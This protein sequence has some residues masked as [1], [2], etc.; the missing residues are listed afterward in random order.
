MG[1]EQPDDSVPGSADAGH[2]DP[3]PAE[4]LADHAQRVGQGGQDHDRGPVLVVVEHR[5]VEDTA[6]PSLDLETP[7]GGDIFKVDPAVHRREGPDDLDD[8][9]RVLG[10]QAYRP[11]VDTAEPFEQCRLALHH[12]DRRRG[13]DVAQTQDRGAVGDHGDGV[14]F[15]RQ[16]AHVLGVFS[17]GGTHPGDA[18]GVGA[19]EVVAVCERNRGDHLELAAQMQKEGAVADLAD[20][21]PR[22]LGD[23]GRDLVGVRDV[24]G[25]AGEV[26]DHVVGMALDDVER[27]HGTFNR[28]DRG[29]QRRRG[30]SADRCMDADG[31]RITGA[32]TGHVKLL[33]TE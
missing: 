4:R 7:W 16:A 14:A 28:C 8:G 6:E 20:D 15:D 24:R 27:R 11:G 18:G 21:H 30:A 17:D 3:S 22:N 5:N 12:R 1:D 25:V 26:D 23:R 19:G 33:D 2:H 13:T 9:I 32:G 10:V 29:R 31:D